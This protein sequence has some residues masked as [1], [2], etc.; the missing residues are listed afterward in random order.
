MFVRIRILLAFFMACT[1]ALT[2]APAHAAEDV[3]NRERAGNYYLRGVCPSNEASA[4][5]S[6]VIYGDDNMFY[7][8]EFKGKRKERVQVAAARFARAEYRFAQHLY[9]PPALWPA[10]VRRP[11][12][13]MTNKT[14]GIVDAA[15][16]ISHAQ[17]GRRVIR[18]LQRINELSGKA[19]SKARIIR[20]RLGLP[21][22]G[23]GC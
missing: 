1:F 9:D 4:R 10:N 20:L 17:G 6:R 5:F 13:I 14:L 19:S 21:N 18:Q 12:R 23:Q 7:A 3:M 11:V 16:K 15:T 8:A 22:T 2:L